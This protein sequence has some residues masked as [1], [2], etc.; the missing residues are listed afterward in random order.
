MKTEDYIEVIGRLEKLVQEDFFQNWEGFSKDVAPRLNLRLGEL[1]ERLNSIENLLVVAI[2]GGSGVGKST[3]INAIA[4]DRIAKMSPFRPCTEK[5]LIYHPPDWRVPENFKKFDCVPK[6]V[7]TNLV[8]IDTPDTDTVVKEHREFVREILSRSDLVLFCGSSEKYLND[9]TWSLLRELKHERTFVLVETKVESL[10]NSIMEN[11]LKAVS[12]EGIKPIA[13]FRVNALASLERKTTGNAEGNEWD[14]P[15][16]EKFLCDYLNNDKVVKHIKELNI[17]GLFRKIQ[18]EFLP[19]IQ[20][21]EICI[22]D[23]RDRI[24][25]SKEELCIRGSKLVEN[26]LVMDVTLVYKLLKFSISS[27]IHGLFLWLMSLSNILSWLSPISWMR[28]LYSV[29]TPSGEGSKGEE[30]NKD[31]EYRMLTEFHGSI[32]SKVKDLLLALEPEINSTHTDLLYMFDT[33]K[34]KK[35][36]LE[37]L[38]DEYKYNL[39]TKASEL[40]NRILSQEILKRSKIYSSYLLLQI[41]YLPIYSFFIYFCWK[42][43][44]GYFKGELIQVNNFLTYSLIIFLIISIVMYWAYTRLIYFSAWRINRVVNRSFRKE[45]PKIINPYKKVEALLDKLE[46]AISLFKENIEEFENRE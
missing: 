18:D 44:P 15:K 22:K 12:E 20:R 14:F 5:P 9:A 3:L 41:F 7:L 27:R 25:K 13:H 4:G 35:D 28:Y 31:M 17:N 10:E 21:A 43:V 19:H 45:L 39:F 36:T 1:K 11:W 23:I 6:S 8:L 24:N 16:L 30:V 46:K 26:F 37:K 29:L 42:L 33:A 38:I 32:A 2:V 40:L 34:I